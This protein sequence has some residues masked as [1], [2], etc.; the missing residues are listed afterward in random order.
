MH[1]ASFETIDKPM[2]TSSQLQPA[3]TN[4]QSL[5]DALR[6]KDPE[7]NALA[8]GILVRVRTE[9]GIDVVPAL[10]RE[11]CGKEKLPNQ[12]IRILEII[13]RIGEPLDADS[14]FSLNFLTNHH[15]QKVAFKAAEV[16]GRLSPAGRR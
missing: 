16:I 5:I 12:R 7:A 4:F 6:T 11:A 9:M 8:A 14:F 13:E 2:N 3:R 10:V 15:V 1:D